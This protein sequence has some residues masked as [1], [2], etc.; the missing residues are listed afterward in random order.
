MILN[1]KSTFK[2]LFDWYLDI[3]EV[4]GKFSYRQMV[5]RIT[6]L[7][8]EIGD[9]LVTHILPVDLQNYREKRRK[10]GIGLA[11]IDD[12][13]TKA[14]M[15]IKKAWENKR[16]RA[17]TLHAL[18]SIKQLLKKNAS[19]RDEIY[20]T[21]QF[22]KRITHKHCSQYLKGILI[23]GFYTGMRKGEILNL[24]WDKIDLKNRRIKLE[25]IDT[26][27][28]E[29]KSCFICK[30]LYQILKKLPR[31]LHDPHVFLYHGK[32][33]ADIKTT[34]KTLCEKA[35]VPYGRKVKG[36]LIFLIYGTHSIPI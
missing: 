9:K 10:K 25:S 22:E 20:S 33:I 16:V 35:G 19:A 12:E 5:Y 1:L 4:K 6:L 2:E 8:K 36:G 17:N 7:N 32:P 15:I 28:R 26:K 30:E 29:P 31:A 13:I 27:T 24:T 14:T 3:E 11:T 23:T 34:F 21:E 18:L